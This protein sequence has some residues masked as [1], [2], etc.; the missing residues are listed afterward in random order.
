LSYRTERRRFYDY[1][2]IAMVG[3]K[4]AITLIEPKPSQEKLQNFF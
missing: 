1:R 3:I 4:H 2:Y